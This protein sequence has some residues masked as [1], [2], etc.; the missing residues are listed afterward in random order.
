MW[1]CFR[2]YLYIAGKNGYYNTHGLNSQKA[3]SW[4]NRRGGNITCYDTIPLWTYFTNSLFQL[5]HLQKILWGWIIITCTDYLNFALLESKELNLMDTMDS[6]TFLNR[7]FLKL[8]LCFWFIFC[9]SPK[10]KR[11]WSLGLCVCLSWPITV[12]CPRKAITRLASFIWI[13]IYC[14]QNPEESHG[15]VIV[16]SSYWP[17]L[18]R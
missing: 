15:F 9:R 12:E 3:G 17:T 4:R 14:L 7:R 2:P 1:L 11:L 13:F 18:E 16:I 8:N 5:W 6:W 10:G